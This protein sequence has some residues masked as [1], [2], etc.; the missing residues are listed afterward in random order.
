VE[1]VIGLAREKGLECEVFAEDTAGMDLEIHRGAA[2]SIDRYR[3]KGI[4]IRALDG[5]RAGYSFTSDIAQRSLRKAFK[6]AADISKS[7]SPSQ[8]DVLADP[9]GLE[10]AAEGGEDI[11]LTTGT[12][13]ILDALVEMEDA[14]FSQSAD[15]VNTQNV[16][17]TERRSSVTVGSS[18][19]FIRSEARG[20]ASFSISAIS[21]KANE[22]RSDW[23]QGQ[24]R[25]FSDI[26]WVSVGREA[27]RRSAG[28]LGSRKI[29]GGR[30]PI[31]FDSMAF[32]DILGFIEEMISAEM[33][34]RG[35]SVLEGKMGK[36]VASNLFNLV[37]DPARKD[38][39]YSSAFDDEGVPRRKY[40]L[41]DQGSLMGYLHNSMTARW[42]GVEPTGNATRGSFKEPPLPGGT[43]LY[44][45]AG[46]SSAKELVSSIEEGIL[47]QDIM[48]MHTA[49]SV[50]GDFSVGVGG[51]LV[52]S[53]SLIHPVCE[54]TVSGNILNLLGGIAGVGD[55]LFFVGSTGSPAVMVEGLSLSGK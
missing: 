55:E 31:I 4:G 53:G 30:Y 44:L 39:L 19:G 9:V 8:R 1:Y 11:A 26:D 42:M 22:T 50:S 45:E 47:V 41:V 54:V 3:E 32:I 2:E 17:Y 28:L 52:T 48:G 46:R 27:A 33:V 18:R 36:R 49:D 12:A 20:Y 38:G 14:A 5:N 13:E 37:D 35:I 51:Y 23:Y 24:G 29:P 6:E 34:I 7:S 10:H 16:A 43:N 21:K 15:I 25:D 40:R